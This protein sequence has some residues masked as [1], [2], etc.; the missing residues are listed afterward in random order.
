MG[1]S[2]T[3]QLM[4]ENTMCFGNRNTVAWLRFSVSHDAAYCC[5][6]GNTVCGRGVNSSLTFQIA[7]YRDWKNAKVSSR[8]FQAH[9]T[10]VCSR[11]EVVNIH[12]C[13][14]IIIRRIDAQ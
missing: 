10:I 3:Q 9:D 11:S 12:V 14:S 1:T 7:G 13:N 4:A 5:Y 2:N 8:G 6:F